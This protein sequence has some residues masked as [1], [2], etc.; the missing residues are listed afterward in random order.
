MPVIVTKL[1]I[2]SLLLN[3]DFNP[4]LPPQGAQSAAVSPRD[5]AALCSV[6]PSQFQPSERVC[7]SL[8]LKFNFSLHS[9]T[10]CVKLHMHLFRKEFSNEL[11]NVHAHEC[12]E[13]ENIVYERPKILQ[14]QA[15]NFYHHHFSSKC[16]HER[17][18]FT[19]EHMLVKSWRFS[20]LSAEEKRLK[21]SAVLFKILVFCW[22]YS[23]RDKRV[24]FGAAENGDRLSHSHP[25]FSATMKT[26]ETFLLQNIC[27]KNNAHSFIF[28]QKKLD[29][30]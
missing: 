21:I 10:K 11:C 5:P 7:W 4:Y 1:T 14:K 26:K 19:A 13:S 6:F 15:W 17:D 9:G 18:I 28:L 2:S 8:V 30:K 23:A 25:D 24:L 20:N 29:W 16:P 22:G 3:F 12:Q 27:A